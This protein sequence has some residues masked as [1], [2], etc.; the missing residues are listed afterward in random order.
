[1]AATVREPSVKPETR[2]VLEAHRAAG[3]WFEAAG[4]RGFARER[5][6]ARGGIVLL[7]HGVPA[8]SFLYRKVM[9]ALADEGLRSVAPDFPGLGLA[10]RP[11]DFDY[12]WSG[13]AHWLGAAVR[14]DRLLGGGRA[15]EAGA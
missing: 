4:V 2:D 3:R 15:R 6:D 5:G 12:S 7:L 9:A 13:L 14:S 8:S 11:V 1:M 10:E